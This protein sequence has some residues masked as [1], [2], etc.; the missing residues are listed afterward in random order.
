MS[1]LARRVAF[2]VAAIPV[3]IWV[4]WQGGLPLALLLAVASAIGAW[5]FYRIAAAGGS[6]KPFVVAGVA[7]SAAIPILVHADNAGWARVPVSVATLAILALLAASIWARGVSGRP[8][9]AVAATV[10]GVL[11]TGVMLS[12]G[13]ALRYY[14]YAI[15][16]RAGAAVV[17]LPVLLTWA[18]DTGAYFVGRALGKRK[19]IP[20]VSPGKTVAGAVGA[21]VVTAVVC[22]LYSRYVLRPAAQLAFSP[23]GAVLFGLAISVVAQVGDL[24]ESLLKREAGVKDSSHVIPGHGGVLDRFDSLLFVLPAAYPL[25]LRLLLPAPL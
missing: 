8:L 5:E 24:V 20:S 6:G 3:V 17:G 23:W 15:D 25:L 16:A 22:V 18:S 10:F 11:Y 13:Y 2:A 9:S 1:E 19:L 14:P 7:A 4:V 12:F 21:L